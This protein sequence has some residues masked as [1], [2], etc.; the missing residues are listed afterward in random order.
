[1]ASLLGV[2]GTNTTRFAAATHRQMAGGARHGRHPNFS[3]RAIICSTVAAR[4]REVAVVAANPPSTIEV[5][6]RSATAAE[7]REVEVESH[8][9]FNDLACY[10]EFLLEE[11]ER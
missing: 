7:R 1:M 4:R 2:R 3:R 11:E 8:M 10:I 9:C 5:I 6:T